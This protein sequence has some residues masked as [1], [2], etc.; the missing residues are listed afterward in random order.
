MDLLSSCDSDWQVQMANDSEHIYMD[1][2]YLQ[3]YFGQ[4]TT[5]ILCVLFVTELPHLWGMGSHKPKAA[6]TLRLDWTASKLW[7]F[8]SLIYKSNNL[9]YFVIATQTN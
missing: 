7:E 3:I 2:T 5:H 9:M 6:R 8:I 4:M 1:S